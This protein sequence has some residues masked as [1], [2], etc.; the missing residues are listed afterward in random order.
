MIKKVMQLLMF[1]VLISF[2]GCGN[3]N[4]DV[5]L[6]SQNIKNFKK[7]ID[8]EE[9]DYFITK[10]KTDNIGISANNQISITTFGDG[11]NYLIDWGDG[12]FNSEVDGNITHTYNNS[13]IYTVKIYG[14]FPQIYFPYNYNN[15]IQ[16]DAQKLISIEQ[17]GTIEWR[18]MYKAFAGCSYLQGNALD[19]PNLSM[20][21]ST[22]AMFL[23]AYS[24][25]QNIDLWDVSHIE[26]MS[27]MFSNASSFNQDIS[28][29]D[30]SNVIYMSHI[31]SEASSFNQDISSWDVSSVQDMSEM[32]YKA[33]SFNQDLSPWDTTSLIYVRGI[34]QYASAFNQDLSLW[35]I[36]NVQDISYIF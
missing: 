35:D 31:F 7:P 12:L 20:V 25:N 32:F 9:S 4:R 18:S 23:D 16:S 29:W 2:I 15:T 27:W 3:S 1:V 8:I 10:W 30:V 24:F 11:Y 26:D 22:S 17:W 28:S 14:E 21:K 6:P 13:G 34:F 36:S 5:V 19:I 33:S